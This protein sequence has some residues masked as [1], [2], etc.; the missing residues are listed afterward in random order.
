MGGLEENEKEQLRE[1]TNK[2]PE[3][4][5]QLQ[6]VE[7]RRRDLDT[8][9]GAAE[10]FLQVLE[11]D[12]AQLE[13]EGRLYLIENGRNERVGEIL[14]SCAQNNKSFASLVDSDQMLLTDYANIFK[15]EASARMQRIM[16]VTA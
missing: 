7:T 11:K 6:S 16:E 3:L 13:D 2:I 8:Y 5:R 9:V 10:G 1:L 4:E 12:P 15:V 14:I